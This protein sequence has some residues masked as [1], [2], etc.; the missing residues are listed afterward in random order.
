MPQKKK[1]KIY[2]THMENIC[3]LKLLTVIALA[4]KVFEAV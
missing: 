3:W 4:E 1:Q 2:N